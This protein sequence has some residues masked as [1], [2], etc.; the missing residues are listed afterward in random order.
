MDAGT[1]KTFR[2]IDVA[3][4]NHLTCI[5]Q[6]MLDGLTQAACHPK[7]LSTVKTL[8]QRF[9]PQTRQQRMLRLRFGLPCQQPKAPRIA[10]AQRDI[11][12][13]QVHMVMRARRLTG[14]DHPQAAG[15]A[16]MNDHLP[17]IETQQ[18]VF[19]PPRHPP[20]HLSGQTLRQIRRYGQT[21][22]RMAYH[23][24]AE[25]ARFDI[26]TDTPASDFDFGQFWHADLALKGATGNPVY[27]AGTRRSPSESLTSGEP[28]FSLC[29]KPG[30]EAGVFAPPTPQPRPRNASPRFT[31]PSDRTMTAS[32]SL[33]FGRIASCLGLSLWLALPLAARAQPSEDADEAPAAHLPAQALTAQTLY[34]F[35]LAEIAGARG[36]LGL[37]VQAYLELARRT[38]DPRIARRAAEIALYAR[39]F[40]A[41]AEAARLWAL[42]D[43]DSDDARHLLAGVLAGGSDRPDSV[44]L[45]F[46]RLLA[47][48]PHQLPH[49]L[50]SLNR[51]L[52]RVGDKAA[53]LRMVERLTEPYLSYREAHFAR[54]QAAAIAQDPDEALAA[55]DGALEL[56]P[57]WEPAVLFKSQLLQQAGAADD[58]L[59][60]IQDH[61]QRHPES[62]NS[63]LMHARLLVA[64]QQ[65]DAARAQ[66]RALLASAP[67]DRDLINAVA[68]LSAQLGDLDEAERLF[69]QALAAGHPDADPI[70][71]NLAQIAERRGDI[72]GALARY[73]TVEGAEHLIEARVRAAQLLARH[74][75]LDEARQ[76]L[77]PAQAD[78]PTRKRLRLAEAQ[79][80]RDANQLAAALDVL[81]QGLQTAPDDPDLLYESAMIAERL[82]RLEVMEGRL[83]KL[84][85]LVPKHAHAYNALGYSLADRGLRLDE[86]QSLIERALE[87]LPDDP[88]ILDSMGWVRFRRG[89][90]AG[91]LPHLERAYALR[92]DPEIAAHL[93]EV[94]WH[95]GRRTEAQRI[96]D[97]AL[98]AHPNHR[99]LQDTIERLQH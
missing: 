22:P 15:H 93:G 77:D 59:H 68:L 72:E 6:C 36:E 53:A 2:R 13:N 29:I 28:D 57:D 76:Q 40:E 50:M 37:S 5:H 97:E 45:H 26:R 89:D 78:E 66:F 35:L 7:P 3:H 11:A 90:P 79:L 58:A 87:L 25:R 84:I 39:N 75:R 31:V 10:Q 55:I 64:T 99:A 95:L 41:A 43:P 46:A 23:Q 73:R 1:K 56:D 34:Q 42:A 92:A 67:E 65:F 51:A 80:L 44:L 14:I 60:L 96:W 33:Q 4:T 83:R 27:A 94:L 47:E 17:G 20:E 98:A 71:L 62:R 30:N 61:L 49:N 70:R 81:D 63:R 21:Q 69:E 24:R 91:A 82:D 32:L 85:A 86:A 19:G 16:Q 9:R 52:A 18:Q 54:A 74:G 8:L 88:F 12:K 48:T 38:A